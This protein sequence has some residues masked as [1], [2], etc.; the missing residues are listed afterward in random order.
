MET[1]LNHSVYSHFGP[2]AI[3]TY[4]I[5][6]SIVSILMPRTTP[7]QIGAN[8]KKKFHSLTAQF[9]ISNFFFMFQQVEEAA[10][11]GATRFFFSL[12]LL[13]SSTFRAYARVG[14]RNIT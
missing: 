6:S 5:H 7:R 4:S 12:S 13:S 2:M 9:L 10:R 8:G 1:N 11:V 3:S 14:H